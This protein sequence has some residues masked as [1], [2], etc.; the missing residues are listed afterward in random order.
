MTTF[1]PGKM[2][3]YCAHCGDPRIMH[4]P[5]DLACVKGAQVIENQMHLSAEEQ[6]AVET[7]GPLEIDPTGRSAHEPG[8]KLD[9]GKMKAAVLSDFALAL[10]EVAK[11]GTFGANKYT[12]G[13]WQSVPGGIERYDD[14]KWRHLLKSRHE[15][16]DA[17]S[18]LR[19]RAHE[20]WN[21]LAV[22]ELE[23]RQAIYER[24]GK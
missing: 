2:P 3:L 5:E 4:M 10:S 21:V 14:A 7:F 13:G 1:R 8:A 18:G 12:R 6:H 24:D 23:L 19:H 20:A 22:L 11:V 17:D 16:I 9:H 15:P